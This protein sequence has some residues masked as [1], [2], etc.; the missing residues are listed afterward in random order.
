M[1]VSPAGAYVWNALISLCKR[2]APNTIFVDVGFMTCDYERSCERAQSVA[3]KAR[4]CYVGVTGNPAFRFLGEV[5]GG[6][7]LVA[8][9]FTAE[10]IPPHNDR[11]EF[12]LVLATRPALVVGWMEHHVISYLKAEPETAH[13]VRNRKGGGGGVSRDADA[14]WYL[15][16]CWN[17]ADDTPSFAGA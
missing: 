4:S 12:M 2:V 14:T 13:K 1:R 17:P 9:S 16:I 11:W 15:Y 6:P 7:E 10:N 8:R 5:P 3:R